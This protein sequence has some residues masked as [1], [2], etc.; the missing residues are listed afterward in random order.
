M[1]DENTQFC[2]NCKH[3]IPEANFTTHEIHCRR[4]IALCDV[5]QEPVPRSDLQEHKQQEH[6]QI[7]CKCGL[8]IE[9]NHVD[10]H[11]SSECSQRLVPCQY[12]ELEIAF[13]QSKEHEDYCG[14][15]TEPCSNC[16]CNVMLREQG[17]HPVLC[18]SLTPP[19]ERNN[20]RTSRSS[21]EPQSPGPWFEAHSIRNLL[22]AQER[23][24]KNNNISAAE[25][26]GFPHPFDT[27]VYNTSGGPQGSGDWKNS[28]PRNTFSHMLEQ[29]DFLTS[30][31]SSSTWP[32]SELTLDEDSSGLD[33]ML[34]L[35][36]QSDGES[37]AGGVE[38]NVWSGIWDHKFGKT[39]NT[40][41]NSSLSLP[42]NN[43]PHFTT[44]TSTVQEH[45]QTDTMLPC[46]FCEEL[47]PEE[48]LILHQ[49]GCSPASAF[50]SY[51]K[52]PTSPP[53]EDRMSRNAS[54]LMH[55]VPD[56]L[57]SNIP[58]FHRSVSPASYSP[59][60]SPLEGDVV[61]PCEFCGI[62]L[63]EAVVFHHQDKCDMRP[64]TAHPLNNLTRTSV[65]KPLSPGKETFSRMSP[66]FQG[67]VKHQGNL[68][69]EDF[70]FDR[71]TPQGQNP[72]EWQRGYIGRPSQRKTSNCDVS[73]TTRPQH[74]REAEGAQSSFCD[75]EKSGSV[76][77][78]GLVPENKEGRGNIRNPMTKKHNSNFCAFK[79]KLPK[80][81]NEEQ[82]EE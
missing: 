13:S 9:K 79:F 75:T 77:L 73:V 24:P 44:S 65:K 34:A 47:F 76:S 71:D 11:Q 68:L 28:A 36:L 2:G 8:K 29:R 21:V 1:S 31:S 54:G 57:A 43:Y 39:F 12:C 55:N 42:N 58:T 66:D 19:Q 62:A 38:G 23:G 33:Y 67:R 70:G 32:H 56:T 20:S 6:T 46:E 45:D 10:V 14:T 18:A 40:S 41:V 78:K 69:E 26:Q 37:V 74:G 17:V 16:K 30:S 81:Q 35:S 52:H 3:D 4:N 25:Q 27:R 64:Q 59:P 49:T 72:R 15:R 61:I 5:C 50:A 80:K 82:E 63:E 22:G 7:T 51:S 53:K 60:A 48:D